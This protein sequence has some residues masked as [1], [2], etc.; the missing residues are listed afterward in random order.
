MEADRQNHIC[1]GFMCLNLK[2]MRE[3]DVTQRCF[4][5]LRAYKDP[6]YI[7]ETALNVVCA[8]H[9]RLF[10]KRWGVYA[11]QACTVD[12]PALI[13]ALQPEDRLPRHLAPVVRLCPP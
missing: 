2:W 5:F 12:R 11:L 4:D 3:N 1:S 13:P 7:D 6:A 9:I 8:G 10:P